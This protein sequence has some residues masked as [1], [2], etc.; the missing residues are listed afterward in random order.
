MLKYVF[1]FSL[2]LGLIS[3]AYFT[4]TSKIQRPL[5]L[6]AVRLGMTLNELEVTFGSPSAQ[7]RNQLTYVFDDASELIVTLRDDT[8]ASAKVKF[9]V[10]LKIEDPKMKELTLVQM[11]TSVEDRPS[12]FF[13]GKPEEGLIYKITADGT[14]ESLTW[15]PPFYYTNSQAKQLQ[16]LLLDFKNQHLSKM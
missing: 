10:P 9:H 3:T 6:D 1:T 11:E 2:L 4:A 15:V 14:I 5:N 13:A 8:V 7:F 16:A 12:W